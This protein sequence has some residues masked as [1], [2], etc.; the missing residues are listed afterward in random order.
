[1]KASPEDPVVSVAKI[2]Q[3]NVTKIYKTVPK[4]FL[5]VLAESN[6]PFRLEEYPV[7][8]CEMPCLIL[9]E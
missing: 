4:A 9:W 5:A 2:K 6:W 8:R 7:S 1:M 3:R